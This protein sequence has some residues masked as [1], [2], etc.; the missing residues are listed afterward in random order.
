MHWTP[1][2]DEVPDPSPWM[3]LKPD[4]QASCCRS[5]ARERKAL[6][7]I[8][9][10]AVVNNGFGLGARSTGGISGLEGPALAPLDPNTPAWRSK[11]AFAIF[12]DE[13]GGSCASRTA[14]SPPQLLAKSRGPRSPLIGENHQLLSIEEMFPA[15]MEDGDLPEC[16]DFSDP[17]D[18]QEQY[19]GA[20]LLDGCDGFG[21]PAELASA[22]LRS[23]GRDC[24]EAE[25][26]QTTRWGQV[27]DVIDEG[28]FP[29]SPSDSSPAIQ[30]WPGPLSPESEGRAPRSPRF[31]P[32]RLAR[33]PSVEMDVSDDEEAASRCGMTLQDL[34]GMPLR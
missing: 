4:A 10:S 9:N 24:L 30:A 21:S 1:Y 17:R 33:L 3:G 23:T 14:A 18:V 6:S 16:Q 13:V 20:M 31:S 27:V 19:R 11:G 8:S 29:S 2:Q 5:E 32:L 28:L 34:R 26:A 7:D 25:A 12:E 15:T 22:L